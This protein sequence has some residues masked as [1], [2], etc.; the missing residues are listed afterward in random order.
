MSIL[1]TARP[2]HGEMQAI[3]AKML[4]SAEIQ[5]AHRQLKP[6]GSFASDA[7]Y[8]AEMVADW[9]GQLPSVKKVVFY[10]DQPAN[11]KA[12]GALVREMGLKYEGVV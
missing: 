4:R 10:D 8:K 2:D 11:L 12:V 5:F 1:L 9:L 7:E 6:V 3:L